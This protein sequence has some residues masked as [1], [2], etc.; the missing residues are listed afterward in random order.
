MGDGQSIMDTSWKTQVL[1]KNH[2]LHTK[3]LQESHA[4]SF[5][6]AHQLQEL[7]NPTNSEIHLRWTFKEKS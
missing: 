1:L 3:L 6:H 4:A 7:K 2:A 5:H